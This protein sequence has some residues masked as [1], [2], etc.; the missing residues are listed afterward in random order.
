MNQ[1]DECNYFL[2][3][4]VGTYLSGQGPDLLG[5]LYDLTEWFDVRYNHG[6]DPYSKSAIGPILPECEA[7]DRKDRRFKGVN[8]ASQ[9]YLSLASHPAIKQAAKEAVDNFG[10]HSAGSPALMGNTLKGNELERVLAEFVNMN[11]C[12]IFPTGWAAA[13]GIIRCLVKKTDHIVIDRLA[14]ASL[15]EGAKS[16]TGN[17]HSFPH[18]SHKALERRLKA[19]R[20]SNPSTGILVVTES[21]YSMDSDVPDLAAHQEIASKY[22]AVLLVD[23]AHDMG[24]QGKTGRGQLENQDLLGKVDIVMGSFSKTFASNGG[25]VAFNHPS[26]R[27]ALRYGSCPLTFSNALSPVQA[28]IVLKAIDIIQSHEGDIR[29]RSLSKNIMRLRE[30]LDKSGFTILG[31]PSPIVPVVLGNSALSRLTAKHCLEKGAL[32]N[33]VEY[34]AVS[35]NSGRLRLQVMAEHSQEQIDKFENIL[36]NSRNLAIEDLSRLQPLSNKDL[37]MSNCE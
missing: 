20:G 1:T 4:S 3:G 12:V 9:D 27:L 32:V 6:L 37:S 23:V 29:R 17:I 7:E 31:I 16:S 19:I 28:S 2:G 21:L 11:D 8:M 22:N 26:L 15:V 14:H 30:K 24:C 13:Y 33:L 5:R 25:F 36:R 18:L 35:R 34:P 10:V